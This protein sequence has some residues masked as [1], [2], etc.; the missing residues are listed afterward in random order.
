[1]KKVERR[2]Y[3]PQS[4]PEEGLPHHFFTIAELKRVF[5]AFKLLEIYIDKT[6]HRAILGKKK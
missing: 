1:L 3:I 5:S 6:N 4:G 2:T